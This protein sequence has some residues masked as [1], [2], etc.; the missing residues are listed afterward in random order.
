LNEY[1]PRLFVE[2][3]AGSA[4]VALQLLNDD[5]V[6]AVALGE[7]D[8]LVASFWKV[9]FNDSDWLISKI[10]R[11]TIS[12]NTWRKFKHGTWKTDQERALACIFLN[13][14]SYSGILMRTAGPIGG[15]EQTSEYT[16]D[17]RFNRKTVIKRI[18]QAAALKDKVLFVQRGD[19]QKTLSKARSLGFGSEA[20]YY[21]DP[22][23]FAKADYLYN[24]SFREQDHL[25]LRRAVMKLK[26]P[27]LLS[28]D[29]AP[30]IRKQYS[31]LNG[32]GPK[33]VDLLYSG[34]RR[35][36]RELIMS[37]IPKLPRQTRIWRTVAEW[38]QEKR[39]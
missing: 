22:P 10:E 17:C 27:W 12:V 36:A 3:F 9:V 14:T 18:R 26:A 29:A 20:F 28:Y 2:P 6:D 33:H 19:W 37:N 7:R 1:R 11:V 38:G 30:W 13:R 4:S 32:H 25:A 31:S 35:L 34:G 8:P 24:F 16:I 23:F 5:L 21:F 15:P 39:A